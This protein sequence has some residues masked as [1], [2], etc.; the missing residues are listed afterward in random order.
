MLYQER[1]TTTERDQLFAEVQ[2]EFIARDQSFAE[3]PKECIVRN[4]SFAEMPK[5]S[6][7]RPQSLINHNPPSRLIP[8]PQRL[9]RWNVSE[10][11]VG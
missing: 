3:V 10:A 4:Q 5:E 6:S 1:E 2:K 8:K 11:F 9:L 7:V